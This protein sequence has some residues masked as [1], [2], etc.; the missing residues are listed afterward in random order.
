MMALCLSFGLV[1]ITASEAG[2]KYVRTTHNGGPNGYSNVRV[3]RGIF[4]TNINCNGPG[5]EVCPYLSYDGPT[6]V[7][8]EAAMQQ[9]EV[10][11]PSVGEMM[12]EGKVVRWRSQN[13]YNSVIEVD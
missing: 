11:G 9:I 13:K 2:A 6:D 4:N 12:H 1:C 3:Q 8:V 10:G 5:M 7:L